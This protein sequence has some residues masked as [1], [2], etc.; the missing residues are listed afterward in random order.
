MKEEAGKKKGKKKRPREKGRG[1]GRIK[2]EYLRV[3]YFPF[4]SLSAG[5]L[6]EQ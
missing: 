1:Q 4:Q 5:G 3:L 2:R 6:E